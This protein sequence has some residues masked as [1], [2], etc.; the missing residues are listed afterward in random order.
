MFRVIDTG[1]KDFSYNIAMDK[2][3]LDLR[4]DNIIPDTLRFLTFKPC[5]LAGFHQSVSN[6]IRI[7][8]CKDKNIDIGRRITGGGAI[9]FDETQL[10]WEL[11]FSSKTLKAANF[12]NLTENI[13]N[14]FV[15]GINRLGINAKFRPR[16]DI[17]VEGKKI[18]GT[19]G[20]YDS[21]IFFFQGTLLLDFN[22]EFMVKSLKI[23]VEK[24]TSKNFDSILA[25]ITSIKKILGYIPDIEIIK[26][27]I[28]GGF[29]EYFNIQFNYGT[30]TEEENNYIRQNQKYYKSDE[31]VYSSDN[32]LLETKTINDTYRCGGGIF[33]TFAKVDYKRNIL[34]YIYFTGDYFVIPERA[35]ADLE[36]FL[37]DCDIDEL[38]FKID[39]FF[40]KYKP[41]FQNVSKE[42]FFNIINNI[43]DKIT[44]LKDAGIKE[45]E[46]SRFMLVNGMQLSDIKSVKAILL[47]YCAKKKDCEFRNTDY[48][49]ICGDCETG[50]AYKFAKDFNL[51]PITI[52]NYENLVEIL[53]EL[54]NKNISSYIGFCCKE[55][56]IR[57]N[58]AFK[59]SGIKALLIDISSPL[60]YNYK[61]EEDAYKGVFDGETLLNAN[62]L[63]DLSK[64][65]NK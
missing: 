54:K 20:T 21:S 49:S 12:Q 32:E 56:Y 63:N 40:E 48:C 41:E 53:N 57:R 46:L 16:N 39:E 22:P 2:A 10:G 19:G 43:A 8:Y 26:S 4:K 23:P 1:L 27:A 58:K 42:D 52:I 30:L 13:C 50:T 29:S 65:I 51:L 47:P 15:S 37:K 45:D 25:R 64:V 60:C 36:S 44:F 7:D 62:I 6:E 61:K 17:E 38:V 5:T 31:W 18:S 55:F 34:K 11:V 33:K 35:I 59:D 14:A 9:Y 24:L 28:I 3:M